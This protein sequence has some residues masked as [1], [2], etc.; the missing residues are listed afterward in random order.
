MCKN[1]RKIFEFDMRD[2]TNFEKQNSCLSVTLE[3]PEQAI[4]T[5]GFL[6]SQT[7][8]HFSKKS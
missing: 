4:A 7:H 1:S 2:F 8:R 3:M 6:L 5:G